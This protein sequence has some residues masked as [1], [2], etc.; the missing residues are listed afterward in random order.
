[1]RDPLPDRF[2]DV[3]TGPPPDPGDGSVARVG[4][5][6]FA[7]ATG[8]GNTARDFY[9]HLPFDRWLVLDHPR[10]GLNRTGLDDRCQIGSLEMPG[11]E[12]A[13][14]LAG[15]DAVFAIQAG[16]APDLWRLAR[17]RGVRT[18]LMP[19]AEWFAPAHP[20]VPLIDRFVAP[21]R[22]C[23]EMLTAVGLGART[24]EIP[25]A[26][27]G[28][29]FAFRRRERA[30]VFLHCRGWGDGDRKGTQFVLEAARR[31]PEIPFIVRAQ[32][33]LEAAWP[34]NVR[35]LGA[36]V[37]PEEQYTDGDVAIQPSR[38]EGV[39]LPILEA[40]ACGLP[41]LV[42]DAPPMNEYPADRRLVVAGELLQGNLVGNPFPVVRTDVDA[43]VVAIRA[44]HGQPIGALSEASR[45]RVA[46]R[47][48]ERLRPAYLAALGFIPE[49]PPLTTP[50][51]TFTP[52]DA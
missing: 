39:G 16:Y 14:W 40:M 34:G 45:A 6:G 21:T 22:S 10:F 20:D 25:H 30:D 42:P 52:A 11:A 2:Q 7:C 1:M 24:V 3:R 18:A 38:Y 33:R 32:E 37:E 26:V 27:D 17:R 5:V 8:L 36:T 9:A 48:W 4:L 47:G 31:C 28:G 15:L 41:T 51:P 13:A 35:L 44:L 12:V 43:L 19:N 23:A 46:E 49:P 50:F 29:R